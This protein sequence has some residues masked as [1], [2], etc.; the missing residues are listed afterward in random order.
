MIAESGAL[1]DMVAA[2]ARMLDAGCGPC[3]GMG[4]APRQRRRLAALLQPQLSRGAAAPP[5]PGLPG[6]RRGVRR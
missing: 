3:I 5:T 2:G 1:A 4:Q 6:Q